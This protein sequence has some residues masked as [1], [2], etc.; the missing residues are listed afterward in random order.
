MNWGQLADI[1]FLAQ[2]KGVSFSLHYEE[3]SESW[4]GTVT[5]NADSENFVGKSSSFDGAISA[6]REWL[7]NL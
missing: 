4:Y 5:S 6:L 7:N 3:S 2:S 1:L